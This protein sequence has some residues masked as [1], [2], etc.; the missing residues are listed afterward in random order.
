MV[1]SPSI[2]NTISDTMKKVITIDG[3]NISDILSFYKEIN[4]IFMTDESWKIGQSLDAFDDMLYGSYGA[5]NGNEP[6][7]LIWK[8]Y[9]ENRGDLG[10]ETTLKYYLEK[11][12][13]PNL[14][15]IN[16]FKQK[17]DDLEKGIGST[18]FD[19]IIEIISSHSNIE[20]IFE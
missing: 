7:Q 4:R 8:N 5:I 9:E 14:Y 6:V 19:T 2:E 16:F 10:I 17:M 18:Y 3:R 20:L 15:N 13:H 1:Q 11:I 12:E